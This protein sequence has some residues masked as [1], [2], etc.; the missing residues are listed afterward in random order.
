V[1]KTI[2]L[3]EQLLT[4]ERGEAPSFGKRKEERLGVSKR[5]YRAIPV[6]PRLR[7]ELI[8]QREREL[9]KGNSPSDPGHFCFSAMEEVGR[10]IEGATLTRAIGR[11]G[12]RSGVGSVTP[13]VLR[14]TAASI[15]ASARS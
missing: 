3:R 9:A 5:S 15:F 2:R 1:A 13:K 6:M 10:P 7:Q 11:S 8:A 12:K 4:L 14:M